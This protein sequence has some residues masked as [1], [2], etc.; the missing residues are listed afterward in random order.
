MA[1]LEKVLQ[2]SA[3]ALEEGVIIVVEEARYRV[4]R[5]PVG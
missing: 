1:R 5:Y 3:Q 2:E 4:R